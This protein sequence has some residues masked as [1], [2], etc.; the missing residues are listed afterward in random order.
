MQFFMIFNKFYLK[1]HKNLKVTV[2]NTLWPRV[3]LPLRAP[4]SLAPGPPG[5]LWGSWEGGSPIP[6]VSIIA[7]TL[8]SPQLP[9]ASIYV[10]NEI[11]LM[12]EKRGQ[13]KLTQK[14]ESIEI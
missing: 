11:Q 3:S 12:L 9:T 6:Q 10:C 8:H 2:F 1:I 7:D 14:I 13:K 5:R 4:E